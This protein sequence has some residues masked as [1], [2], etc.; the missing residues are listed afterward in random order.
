M[1]GLLIKHILDFT[2]YNIDLI[3]FSCRNLNSLKY[4]VAFD[5]L[6]FAT[7]VVVCIYFFRSMLGSVENTYQGTNDFNEFKVIKSWVMI[8]VAVFFT[9]LLVQLVFM[10]CI[11]CEVSDV[12]F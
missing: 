2:A 6:S 1:Y 7:G 8:E 12:E 3:G 10:M 9:A 4:K 11:Y 5:I